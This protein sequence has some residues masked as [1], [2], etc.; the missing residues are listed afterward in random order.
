M[1]SI[2]NWARLS[3]CAQFLLQLEIFYIFFLINGVISES[4][5]RASFRGAEKACIMIK[6]GVFLKMKWPKNQKVYFSVWNKPCMDV[7]MLQI[8]KKT[9]QNKQQWKTIMSR[10]KGISRQNWGCSNALEWLRKR[11]FQ[12]EQLLLGILDPQLTD[13]CA[14]A[15]SYLTLV[16]W[17]H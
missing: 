3:V 5:I 9:Q 15:R 4:H 2:H 1:L 7:Y 10:I 12:S 13:R 14:I 17:C 8:A 16:I 6:K 11:L